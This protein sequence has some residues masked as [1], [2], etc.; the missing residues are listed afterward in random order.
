M[1][2]RQRQAVAA[3]EKAYRDSHPYAM[4]AKWAN[5]HAKRISASGMVS[6]ADVKTAWELSGGRCWICGDVADSLDHYRPLN[7]RSG[8][9]NTMDNIRP[10]CRECNQKR[11]HKWHGVGIAE[12][13]AALLRQ[14]KAL[15][16]V[17]T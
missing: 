1:T 7:G 15:L 10:I 6:E 16:S 17:A 11:S 2:D 13:E 9:T 4:R 12:K 5:Q 3:R 8:G 14:L